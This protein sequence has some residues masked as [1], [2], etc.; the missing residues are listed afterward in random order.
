MCAKPTAVG[1]TPLLFFYA[2][3]FNGY[4]Y[5][6]Q[7][8]KFAAPSISVPYVVRCCCVPTYIVRFNTLFILFI[9]TAN[10]VNT[11]KSGLGNVFLQSKKVRNIFIRSLKYDISFVCVKK[12]TLKVI[13]HIISPINSAST[14][15]YI[16]KLTIRYLV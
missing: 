7:K 3:L 5:F 16:L 9:A 12:K 2:L 15:S 8:K 10:V 6:L 13:H 11:R 14:P 4:F 1:G